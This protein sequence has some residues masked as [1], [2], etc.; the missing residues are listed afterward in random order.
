MMPSADEVRMERFIRFLNLVEEVADRVFPDSRSFR[1]ACGLLVVWAFITATSYFVPGTANSP[2]TEAPIALGHALR[3]AIY[4]A[5][6]A[7]AVLVWLLLRDWVD[8]TKR[9]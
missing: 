8:E 5:L 9:D 2:A 4:G 1:R 3:S 7:G 6:A